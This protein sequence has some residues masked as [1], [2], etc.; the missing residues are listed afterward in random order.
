LGHQAAIDAQKF[1]YERV[2][3]ERAKKLSALLRDRRA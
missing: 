1:T 3:I 2:G